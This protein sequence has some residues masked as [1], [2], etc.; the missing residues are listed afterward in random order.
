MHSLHLQRLILFGHMGK[1]TTL[2]RHLIHT[3]T[4]ANIKTCQ[5]M[6]VL[7]IEASTVENIRCTEK[8]LEISKQE[9]V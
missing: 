4:K 5:L 3:F 2:Q 1:V 8:I 6:S 7:E 9:I